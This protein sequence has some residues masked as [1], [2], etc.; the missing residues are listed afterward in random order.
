MD[1]LPEKI[2]CK[3]SDI[4]FFNFYD[5]SKN[6]HS[7]LYWTGERGINNYFPYNFEKIIDVEWVY[8]MNLS[9]A[10]LLEYFCKANNINLEWYVEKGIPKKYEKIFN[11]YKVLN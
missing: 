6:S 5:V 7:E 1:Y 9:K 2:I 3:F 10:L 4:K 8:Y 11:N